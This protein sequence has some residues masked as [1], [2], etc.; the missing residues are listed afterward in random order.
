L[1]IL[2]VI[3]FCLI[4]AAC[5]TPSSKA[6]K[7]WKDARY[8][9]AI[10]ILE[11]ELSLDE[12]LLGPEHPD[13]AADLN[14]LAVTYRALGDYEKVLPL[15]KRA[16]LIWEKALGQEHR[17]V[18][19]CLNNLANIYYILG[20]YQKA[21]PLIKR[22]LSIKRKK[23]GHEHPSVAESLNTLASIY[24]DLGD[25]EK[26]EPL[27][28]KALMIREKALGLEHPDVASTLSNLASIYHN[29]GDYEKAKPLCKKALMIREKAL[30]LEHPD[31]AE[32]LNNLARIYHN[33]GD[34]AKAEALYKRA[35]MIRERVLGSEHP[36]LPKVLTNLAGVYHNLGDYEK[37]E[38]LYKRALEIDDNLIDQVMGFTS[39]EQKIKFLFLKKRSLHNYFGLVV[40]YL[41]ENQS[42]KIDALNVWLKRKG[43]SMEALKRFQE[44]LVYDPQAL[45]IFHELSSVRCRLSK[46]ALAG[47]GRQSVTAYRRNIADLEDQKNILES[48]LSQISH[49][50]ALKQKMQKADC[51]K[52]ARALPQNTALIDFAKVHWKSPHYIVFVLHANRWNEVEVIDLGNAQSIDQAVATYKDE[53]VKH[54]INKADQSI[55]SAQNIY[56]LVFAPLKNELRDVKEIFISPDGDLSLIPFEVFQS[57]E[58]KF[59]IEDYTFNYLPV[60]RDILGFHQSQSKRQK[61]LL[62]GDP[63]FDMRT[64]PNNYTLKRLA[65]SESKQQNMAKRSSDMRGLY[66]RRLNGTRKEVKLIQNILGKKRTDLYIGQDALEEVLWNRGSPSPSILH[67]ATH[68]FFLNNLEYSYLMSET[69]ER[70]ERGLTV[71]AKVPRE[72]FKIESPLLRSGIALAGANTSIT[73]GDAGKTDGIITAE[74]ILGIRL[75]DT[76][77]VVLSACETGIGEVKT[78]EGVFGLQRAFIQAGAKSLVMSM[79][80][81]PDKETQELMAEFYKNIIERGMSRCQALRQAALKQMKTVKA[82]YVHTNPLFCGAFVFMGE[83]CF[84]QSG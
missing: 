81:F 56:N 39:E 41:K 73:S 65:L 69:M 23:L 28:K 9:E 22:S 67:L 19:T 63:D 79:W 70:M 76:E 44:A 84:G 75:R 45:K 18:A 78:G 30:G 60:S 71:T 12:K 6:F 16:L 83:A 62:I 49:D 32:S 61:A 58:D 17:N 46:L 48:R 33:L 20:D 47:P 31:V 40:Q 36:N 15:Y 59:L 1:R 37:A 42:A 13:V 57:P 53:I 35:L 27:Y 82:R 24:Y 3:A 4:S 66:F 2:L 14:N 11:Q 72:S 55:E 21:L 38:P 26:A 54:K 51:E 64:K 25:Y 8:A 43:V 77:M 29:L 10:P 50:Y 34:Y 80:A 68:G 5:S 74:E 7:L 52:I